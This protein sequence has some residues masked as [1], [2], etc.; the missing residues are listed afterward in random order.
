MKKEFGLWFWVH[1]SVLILALLS[2]LLVD[3][4]FII[5]GIIIL[6]IQFRA[7]GG[8]VLTHWEM[9]KDT[10]Q[11]FILHYLKKIFPNL[12]TQKVG[13]VIRVIMPIFITVMG[14]ILQIKLGFKPYI[15]F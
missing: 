9:G 8:C 13:F 11:T 12:N 10:N 7:I 3:W 15:N 5:L 1:L 6:E 14:I 2:P 4:K